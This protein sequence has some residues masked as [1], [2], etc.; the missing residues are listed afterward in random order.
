MIQKSKL[1]LR[2]GLGL[3]FLYF[4]LNQFFNPVFWQDLVPAFFT[5]FVSAKNIIYLNAFFD[6]LVALFLILNKYLKIVTFLAFL[7]L[8]I[9]SFYLGF[10]PSGVRDFGLAMSVLALF[11]LV[12]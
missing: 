3:V 7:H 6:F 1:I 2:I 4:S 8:L 5:E 9:L 12:K 11:F 10:N